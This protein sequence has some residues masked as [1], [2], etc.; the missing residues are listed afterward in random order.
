MLKEGVDIIEFLPVEHA[1]KC[2]LASNGALVSGGV[3][4]IR[5]A[6]ESHQCFWHSGS[7][8]GVLPSVV[9]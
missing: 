4:E 3:D 2:L 7:V 6:L 5:Q 8:G 1:G 9:G